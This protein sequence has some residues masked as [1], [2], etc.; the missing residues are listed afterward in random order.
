[1]M[2][3]LEMVLSPRGLMIISFPIIHKPSST[4][5]ENMGGM[6]TRGIPPAQNYGG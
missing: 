3:R 1:M 4:K 2:L 6:F 5:T